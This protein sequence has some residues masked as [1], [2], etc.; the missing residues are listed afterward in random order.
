MLSCASS[1]P[2][3]LN[4]FLRI[5]TCLFL[6]AR[7]LITLAG[8]DVLC[9]VWNIWI[10]LSFSTFEQHRAIAWM[11]GQQ[12]NESNWEVHAT[13]KGHRELLES[14]FPPLLYITFTSFHSCCTS[15]TKNVCIFANLQC[16]SLYII[17]NHLIGLYIIVNLHSLHIFS[18]LIHFDPFC[19]WGIRWVFPEFT[20]ACTDHYHCRRR[21]RTCKDGKPSWQRWKAAACVGGALDPCVDVQTYEL[22]IENLRSPL[23]NHARDV[24]RCAQNLLWCRNEFRIQNLMQNWGDYPSWPQRRSD[25]LYVF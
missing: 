25:A 8:A 5:F 13:F 9:I 17:V 6:H 10:H 3:N 15:R 11:P 7:W 16:T 18:I 23:L 21:K 20:A 24:M 14:R 19:G 12:D 1:R 2:L 22:C 4:P